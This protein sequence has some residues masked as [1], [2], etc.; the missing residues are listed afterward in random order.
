MLLPLWSIFNF[1]SCQQT[2][3][4]ELS[5]RQNPIDQS[6][7]VRLPSATV[8]FGRSTAEID[9]QA[10]HIQK[11]DSFW[12]STTEVTNAQF[13]TFLN[14]SN[15]PV[16]IRKGQVALR[17]YIRRATEIGER[18]G[19]Y[20]AR[21]G[22]TD[23]PVHSVNYDIASEYCQWA[24]GRLPTEWEWEYAARGKRSKDYPWG[25]EAPDGRAQFNKVWDNGQLPAP[26]AIVASFPSNTFGIYDLAGNVAEWTSSPF[27]FY[28]PKEIPENRTFF[29]KVVRGGSFN[30]TPERL[31]VD[32]RLPYSKSEFVIYGENIGFRCVFEDRQ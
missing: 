24:G 22:Y 8:T 15:K 6:T 3:L 26:T 16:S 27:L 11:I 25:A 23:H 28:P 5:I 30:S 7:L 12:I 9:A 20:Y 1:L 18:D 32:Y 4:I 21:I 14:A 17:G 13:T 29:R 31:L 19:R 2:V 10:T